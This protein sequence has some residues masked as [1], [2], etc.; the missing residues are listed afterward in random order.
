MLRIISQTT[1]DLLQATAAVRGF[2]RLDPKRLAADGADDHRLAINE[3]DEI[4]AHCSLWW[5]ETPTMPGHRVGLIGHYAAHH[6]EAGALLL[7]D[8]CAELCAREADMV[9]GPM[10]G[11]TWRR[12]RFITERGDEPPFFLEPD[13]CDEWPEQFRAAGF[14]SLAEYT[15]A[16][17]ANL[18]IDDEAT[19]KWERKA[20]DA[21]VSIR[22]LDADNFDSELKHLYCAVA[23]SFERNFLY[24]PIR[25]AEFVAQYRQVEPFVRPELVLLAERE[26]RLV[27]FIF[28]VP[29]MAQ[30][31]RGDTMDTF[32]VKT[33]GVVPSVR[34]LGLGNLLVARCQ[35]NARELGFKRVI[36]ALM[37]DANVSRNISSHYARTIRRYTLYS[38][39][40]AR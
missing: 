14:E 17:G 35:A 16:L 37:I 24:T 12:Y 21:G 1:P 8:A 20:R 32:I 25:E 11:S 29:D 9:I 3:N 22:T 27:G 34:G 2:K 4:V 15:S 13:N 6:A 38:R 33:L 18:E 36:H 19:G 39:K 7:D 5:R 28:G 40:L 30:A 23:E 31:Q 10:D 26:G